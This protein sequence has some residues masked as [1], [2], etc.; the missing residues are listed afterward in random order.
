MRIPMRLLPITLLFVASAS[1]QDPKTFYERL[2]T[3]QPT[4]A[5]YQEALSVSDQIAT[6]PKDQVQD[7]LPLVF[8][9]IKSDPDGLKHSLLGLY[10][11]SR[12]PDSGEVLKPYMKDIGALLAHPHPAFKA[13]AGMIFTNMNP[14]PPEAADILLGFI[15]GP[16]GSINEKI[17]VLSAL[18]RLQNPPKE[19]ID[20]VAIPLLKQPMAASTLGAAINA[21]I[22]RGASD[23]MV[24]AIAEHLNHAD[25]QVRMRAIFAFRFFGP[26][27]IG[28]YRGQLTKMANDPKQPDAVKQ[29][30]QNTLD[31]K[32]EK[33]LI[34]QSNPPQFIPAP[35]CKAN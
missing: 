5:L 19:K 4:H 10:T 12:R 34:L 31:G 21:S 13:T 26:G 23:A 11:I 7:L 27:A 32:D 30:A 25:W 2:P 3:A 28:R 18:T 20:A 8:V 35:G 24:D 33:C 16:T 1:A 22:Y 6:L 17:D 9:A 29:Y 15:S 14:Q